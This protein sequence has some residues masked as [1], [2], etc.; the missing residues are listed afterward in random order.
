MHQKSHFNFDSSKMFS[1]NWDSKLINQQIMIKQVYEILLIL[2]FTI[3]YYHNFYLRNQLPHS[4]QI[5]AR[6][7]VLHTQCD[8][9]WEAHEV[10]AFMVPSEPDFSCPSPSPTLSTNFKQG[11]PAIQWGLKGHELRACAAAL[12]GTFSPLQV[13]LPPLWHVTGKAISNTSQKSPSPF[14]YWGSLSSPSQA[15]SA[16]S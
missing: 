13:L 6:T 15:K 11:P 4:I 8:Y 10:Q 1:L 3:S 2:K 14:Q 7:P 12:T 16:I 9:H 5:G